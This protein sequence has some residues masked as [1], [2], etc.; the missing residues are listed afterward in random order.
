MGELFAYLHLRRLLV[1]KAGDA[2]DLRWV[3]KS[4]ERFGMP[5]GDDDLGYD[6]ELIDLQGVFG[7]RGRTCFVEVKATMGDGSGAFQMSLPEWAKAQE[8]ETQDNSAYIIAR[9]AY[10]TDP[11]RVHM[12]ALLENPCELW[13]KGVLAVDTAGLYMWYGPAEQS[14]LAEGLTFA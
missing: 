6:I 10:V 4:R 11:E 2:E 14:P 8:C 13:R 3:S 9:V 12:A 1:S 7:E 5:E